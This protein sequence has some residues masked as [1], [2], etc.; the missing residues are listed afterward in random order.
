MHAS[1]NS[2]TTLRKKRGAATDR[3]R[4]AADLEEVRGALKAARSRVTDLE[5]ENKKLASQLDD[6][7]KENLELEEEED[8][9]EQEIEEL[10]SK[11]VKKLK[12]EIAGLK[13]RH[14]SALLAATSTQAVLKREVESLQDEASPVLVS[15]GWQI[16]SDRTQ[17]KLCRTLRVSGRQA[18]G[19]NSTL[20]LPPWSSAKIAR[21]SPRQ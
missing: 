17:G 14:A 13:T 1:A 12:D 20:P 4:A 16:V 5:K 10:K 15:Q 19:R 7:M 8:M 21:N 6:M 9:K 18:R 11:H 2:T 3:M